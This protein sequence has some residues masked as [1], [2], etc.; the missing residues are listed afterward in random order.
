MQKIK[1][2][3]ASTMVSWCLGSLQPMSAMTRDEVIEIAS[4]G[5]ADASLPRLR[6]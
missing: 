1:G 4:L 6:D 3:T 2:Q 5:P